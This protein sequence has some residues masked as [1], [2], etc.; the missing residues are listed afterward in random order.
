MRLW[1]F[2]IANYHRT[3][4]RSG[5]KKQRRK[6]IWQP[7]ATMASRITRQLARVHGDARPGEPLHVRHRGVII[8]FRV[9]RLL[10]F[11]NVEY[12][13]RRGVALAAAADAR[14]ADK[15]A[16]AIHI[17]RLLR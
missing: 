17:H 11:E 13:R 16:V 1:R 14:A 5:I 8:R 9:M 12:P 7:D 15:N 3:A 6:I 2:A 10:L 4:F